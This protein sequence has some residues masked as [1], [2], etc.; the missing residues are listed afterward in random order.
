MRL[1]VPSKVDKDTTT[2]V[3]RVADAELEDNCTHTG[4]EPPSAI[5]VTVGI[6]K[7]TTENR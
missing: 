7:E 3:L 5:I 4:A 1:P 6:A 2:S